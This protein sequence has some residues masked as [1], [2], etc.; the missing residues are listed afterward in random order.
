MLKKVIV[1]SVAALV[2]LSIFLASYLDD[3]NTLKDE[4]VKMG[5]SY[6]CE[7]IETQFIKDDCFEIVEEKLLLLQK[8]HK[9][10]GKFAKECNSLAY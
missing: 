3:D 10:H 8:C 1:Y 5:D 6:Y 9:E 2:I 4:A 7:K